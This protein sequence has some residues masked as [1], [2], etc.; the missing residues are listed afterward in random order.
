MNTGLLKKMSIVDC[1]HLVYLIIL[2]LLTL[3]SAPKN[4]SF[5]QALS[6]YCLLLG[7][8]ILLIN[9]RTKIQN[10]SLYHWLFFV[11]PAIYVFVIFESLSLLLPALNPRTYDHLFINIDYFLLK[12]HPTVWLERFTQPWLTDVMFIFYSCY[13]IMPLILV[14]M[15]NSHK[16][17]KNLE[18]VYFVMAFSF[19][20]S[21]LCYLLLPASG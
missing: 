4:K 21:Y 10:E 20:A 13:F 15:I 16:R 3:V 7:V 12:H 2:C 5:N 6:L 14:L 19:Y 9:L 8:L 17:I 1:L 18:K 11:Y